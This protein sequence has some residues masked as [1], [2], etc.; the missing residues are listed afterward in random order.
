MKVYLVW[1]IRY[2]L[3]FNH[4]RL[5]G[6]YLS[7]ESADKH[8]AELNATEAEPIEEDDYGKYAGIE[9]EVYENEAKP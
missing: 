7:K 1:E 2:S 8:C 9:F 5:K 3:P 4:N 6:V